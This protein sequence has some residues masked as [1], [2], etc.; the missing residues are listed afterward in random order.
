MKETTRATLRKLANRMFA[1]RNMV[2]PIPKS[3]SSNFGA[4]SIVESYQVCKGISYRNELFERKFLKQSVHVLEVDLTNK[5]S[6]LQLNIPQPLRSLQTTEEQAR[7]GKENKVLAA[8]NAAFFETIEGIA[9]LP[10]SLIVKDGEIIR[11]GRNSENLSGP[12]F[13]KQAFGLLSNGKAR[14][15]EY[16]SNITMRVDDRRIPVFSMND[17]MPRIGKAVL[18][19]ESDKPLPASF[20]SN[21]TVEI[22]VDNVDKDMKTI[23]FGTTI[24]GTVKQLL[25]SS[26][27]NKLHVPKDGF[28]IL[29]T[30]NA[31]VETLGDIQVGSELSVSLELDNHWKEANFVLG[32]GPYLVK[33]GETHITMNLSSPLASTRQPRTAVGISEDGSKVLLITVD[34]RQRGYSDGMTMVEL[35]DFFLTCGMEQAINLDGGGSSTM[36][37]QK[38]GDT[39]PSLVNRPADGIQRKVSATI[40]LIQ[41]ESNEEFH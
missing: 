7:N 23:S 32:S 18:Y 41:K 29:A 15:G 20:L 35:A 30:G 25:N 36:V 14:I 37:L 16:E 8:V 4:K 33:N 19:T 27:K 11:Y 3:N 34:G 22:I 13:Q 12:I 31:M 2:F 10:A 38:P 21:P 28:V 17:V 24:T 39:M 1:F 26:S 40:Q 6:E 5:D 9:G